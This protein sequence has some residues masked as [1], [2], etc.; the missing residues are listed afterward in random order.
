MLPEGDHRR[1]A[2]GNGVN[3]LNMIL[4]I[5]HSLGGN[6]RLAG[7]P[8]MM[9]SLQG[10]H[11]PPPTLGQHTDEVLKDILGYTEERIREIREKG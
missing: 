11:Q 6:V 4:D 9:P 7:N 3:H 5:E 2:G 10:S 1:M 8:I